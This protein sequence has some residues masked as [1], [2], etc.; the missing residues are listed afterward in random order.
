MYI[1][2]SSNDNGIRP[3]SLRFVKPYIKIETFLDAG[4]FD[5]LPG[6]V[7]HEVGIESTELEGKKKKGRV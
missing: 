6:D 5:S 4:N 1:P 2:M 7:G 3:G